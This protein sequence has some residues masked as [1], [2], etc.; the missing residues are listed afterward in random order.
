MI[1]NSNEAD[2]TESMSEEVA[3]NPGAR[4]A[5]IAQNPA[6][7]LEEARNAAEGK[8]PNAAGS[9]SPDEAENYVPG[10][11]DPNPSSIP[12]ANAPDIEKVREEQ[13]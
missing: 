10:T 12:T 8:A 3:Q 4:A 2:N 9:I 5:A 13:N 1:E 11:S 6:L 7:S